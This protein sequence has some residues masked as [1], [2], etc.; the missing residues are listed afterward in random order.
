MR[1]TSQMIEK[2][3]PIKQLYNQPPKKGLYSLLIFSVFQTRKFKLLNIMSLKMIINFIK[4]SFPSFFFVFIS[5]E[6]LGQI[7]MNDA[8]V[9]YKWTKFTLSENMNFDSLH[10]K[11]NGIVRKDIKKNCFRVLSHPGDTLLLS[12]NQN[13]N[14]IFVCETNEALKIDT[15]KKPQLPMKQENQDAY[16]GYTILSSIGENISDFEIC[17]QEKNCIT[18]DDLKAKTSILYFWFKGCMPCTILG[19]ALDKLQKEYA[20]NPDIQ[21]ISFCRDKKLKNQ[22]YLNMNT[23]FDAKKFIETSNVISF[24][25]V[26]ILDKNAVIRDEFV[27]AIVHDID[28]QINQI[29][30]SGSPL[31]LG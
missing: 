13:Q 25:V 2:N 4:L 9:A 30:E 5:F 1:T 16:K 23:Y 24:P 10:F 7:E 28:L 22:L 27:G 12:L 31:F 15:D 19:P 29:K 17:N 26:L 21:F 11:T 20:N 18:K 8:F 14:F 6:I 3:I